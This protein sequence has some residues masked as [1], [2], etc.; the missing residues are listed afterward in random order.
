MELQ[1]IK[2]LLPTTLDNI[3]RN[4]CGMSIGL[5][6]LDT[7]TSGLYPGLTVIASRPCMGKTT[8]ALGIATHAA[9]AL[10]RKVTVLSNRDS[11]AFVAT[12]LLFHVAGLPISKN[13][14]ELSEPEQSKV[15]SASKQLAEADVNIIDCSGMKLDDIGNELMRIHEGD[16][17]GLVVIDDIQGMAQ[18]NFMHCKPSQEEMAGLLA[19]LKALS[20]DLQVP[21][22]LL[23]C[24]PRSVERR[25]GR[26]PILRDLEKRGVLRVYANLMILL[27]KRSFYFPDSLHPDRVEFAIAKNTNGRI[28]TL[29]MDF[30]SDS[31]LFRDNCDD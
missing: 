23:S 20:E 18:S 22:L 16:D 30:D 5:S 29:Y 15:K 12:R 19:G 3:G 9:L 8:L 26:R 25:D 2:H 4:V 13:W 7:I 21:F 1:H 11:E 31:G 6:G 24:L 27:Y 14:S 10:S 28:G 17:R